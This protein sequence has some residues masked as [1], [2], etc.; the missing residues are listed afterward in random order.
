MSTLK[1]MT[2]NVRNPNSG[3]Q[4]HRALTATD[5]QIQF[6]L[7]EG[8]NFLMYADAKKQGFAPITWEQ[9]MGCVTLSKVD[10]ADCPSREWG[11]LVKK[12][13]IPRVLDLP[14]NGGVTFFGLIDK[15]TRIYLPNQQ[16][17]ELDDHMPYK[18]KK[19]YEAA[20]I[21][22]TVYLYPSKKEGD[23]FF[24]HEARTALLKLCSVNIRVIAEDPTLVQTCK[25]EGF[26]AK[27]FDDETDCY[28]IPPHL[29]GALYTYVDQHYINPKSQQPQDTKNDELKQTLI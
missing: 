13:V 11:D 20:L 3:G 29:E 16:W 19:W 23:D 22:N 1:Q 25:G 17:G 15:R 2:Y 5:R 21:G 27:C 18:K 26:E 28:P 8:R 24:N 12:V 10:Q 4:S 6:W 9:D 7:K 14:D